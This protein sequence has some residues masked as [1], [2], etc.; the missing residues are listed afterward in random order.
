MLLKKGGKSLDK[1]LKMLLQLS[2]VSG[3]IGV[4]DSLGVDS[5]TYIFPDSFFV[6]QTLSVDLDDKFSEKGRKLQ[7]TDED[8]ND[9]LCPRWEHV[10]SMNEGSALP[11][12]NNSESDI[13]VFKRTN[14]GVYR[15]YSSR[16]GIEG[17][18]W[19]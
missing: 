2:S 16:I 4:W 19:G 9:H 8:V 14:A 7:R 3:S 17:Q 13:S 1:Y 6:V 18:K 15:V 5:Q 10:R 12:H 11:I